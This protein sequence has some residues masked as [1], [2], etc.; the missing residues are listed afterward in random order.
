M[1]YYFDT[2]IFEMYPDRIT[3][4]KGDIT[5]TEAV[6]AAFRE[7]FDTVIN[8]AASVKHFADYDSLMAVNLHGVENLA[9]LCLEKGVRLIH[10]STL[11][12]GGDMADGAGKDK[13]LRENVLELG[14]DVKANAYV[15]SKYLAER[16]VI[17]RIEKDGLDAKIMRVGNL[18][19]RDRDGEFQMNFRTNNFV[20]TLR[21]YSVLRCF[22]YSGLD[23]RVEFSP[24]DE[25]AAAIVKLSGTGREFTVF[26]VNN[27]NSV[28][29]GEIISVMRECGLDIRYAE[30]EIFDEKVRTAL[31]DDRINSYIAPL[32][33]YDADNGEKYEE[34]PAENS[35][36]IKALYR[37]GFHWRVTDSEYLRKLIEGL[38]TL[39]FFDGRVPDSASMQD[40]LDSGWKP[41][42]ERN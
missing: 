37:L 39:G 32:V 17:G 42:T 27:S 14:Q 36:T 35:F 11:S 34:V 2:D 9:G 8:C 3:V 33:N 19:G 15:Y 22:P 16:H 12:V 1:Y 20:N 24:I 29:M 25:T 18:M 41:H 5:D 26:H 4:L 28:E 21:A 23:E 7:H 6:K 10:V 13:V 40:A 38:K 30:D 31:L